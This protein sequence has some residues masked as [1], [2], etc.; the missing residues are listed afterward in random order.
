MANKEKVFDSKKNEEISHEEKNFSS[1]SKNLSENDQIPK[2]ENNDFSNKDEFGHKHKNNDKHKEL[3]VK[4]Y[5]QILETKIKNLEKDFINLNKTHENEKLRFRS[6]LENFTK[7]INK[8]R[9]N[10]RK[11]ASINF[12]EN[13]LVPFDQF[14]KVLE[15]NVEDEIL[16]KF[17]V[18]FKM[19]H[20]QMKNIFKE[21][22]LE[23]IESLGK[24]FDPKL[25]YAIEKISD[26]NQ[27]NNSNIEVLQKGYLYKERVLKPAMVKVNEWSNE[28]NDKDK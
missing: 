23:E 2:V 5:I 3:N 17:L 9:I 1:E 21:E 20:Q 19:V 10:E 18:G 28:T 25:H 6:D 8:E 27:P 7:R 14:E 4:D 16:K 15:M 11:Y 26:K 24:I 13:I 12:I 22:G